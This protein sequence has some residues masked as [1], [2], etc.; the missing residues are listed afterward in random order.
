VGRRRFDHLV[1][2]VSLAIDANVPR[3]AMWLALHDVGFDPDAL[4]AEQA[5][6]FCSGPLRRFLSEHGFWL[7]PQAQVRVRRAVER[8]DPGVV[9]PEEHFA[10]F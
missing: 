6:A 4:S 7:S 2:E 1:T 3:Y 10:R 8:Y 9:T 5:T